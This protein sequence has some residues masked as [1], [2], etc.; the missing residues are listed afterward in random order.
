MKV[1]ARETAF[2]AHV[3]KKHVVLSPDRAAG[4]IATGPAKVYRTV[5]LSA[6]SQKLRSQ[7]FIWAK[8][9]LGEA[10]ADGAR[11]Y[12][13]SYTTALLDAWS[14][15]DYPEWGC[16]DVVYEPWF[17]QEVKA[18]HGMH[19]IFDHVFEDGK[20][21]FMA[22][23]AAVFEHDLFLPRRQHPSESPFYVPY[24]LEGMGDFTSRVWY[25]RLL[26][27]PEWQ[28][29]SGIYLRECEPERVVT[30]PRFRPAP[31]EFEI[32][33]PTWRE[34]VAGWLQTAADKLRGEDHE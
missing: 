30:T 9:V 28:R 5:L 6:V 24:T 21:Q 25:Q 18:T 4:R 20:V 19:R 22:A 27:S 2:V 10:P 34:R 32:P 15:V 31:P 3:G 7:S 26:L 14:P 12:E 17:Y 16:L 11:H 23:G 1:L 33:A 29:R 8:D 13:D